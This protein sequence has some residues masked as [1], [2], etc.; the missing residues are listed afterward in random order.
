MRYTLTNV[1][2][3]RHTYTAVQKLDIKVQKLQQIHITLTTPYRA[4][5]AQFVLY[6]VYLLRYKS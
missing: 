6:K 4:H 5:V 2:V 1:D 3:F